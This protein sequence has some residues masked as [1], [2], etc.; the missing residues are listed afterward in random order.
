MRTEKKIEA[1]KEKYKN[2][3]PKETLDN[4]FMGRGFLKVTDAKVEN[5][6]I[7]TRV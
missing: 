2:G 1:I 6:I 3:V 7:Q 4:F 5:E